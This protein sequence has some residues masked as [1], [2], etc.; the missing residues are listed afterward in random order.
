MQ[1]WNRRN[2]SN[3]DDDDKHVEFKWNWKKK[4]EK[5]ERKRKKEK[6]NSPFFSIIYLFIKLIIYWGKKR[7]QKKYVIPL[8]KDE[9]KKKIQIDHLISFE[10]WC[11]FEQAL[12]EKE[13]YSY[14]KNILLN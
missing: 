13:N 4:N 3:G 14:I 7:K 10:V 2:K 6:W 1:E 11:W 9:K 8:W 12:E 5:D